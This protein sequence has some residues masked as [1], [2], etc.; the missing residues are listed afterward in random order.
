MCTYVHIHKCLYVEVPLYVY[1]R[2]CAQMF[3]CRGSTVHTY[4]CVFF[5]EPL[6][7]NG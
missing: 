7:V 3:V 6:V 2:T 1:I 5:S 4:V